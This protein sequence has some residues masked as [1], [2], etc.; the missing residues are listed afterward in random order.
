MTTSW[1]THPAG[2]GSS[3]GTHWITSCRGNSNSSECWTEE[4]GR[5]VGLHRYEDCEE[6]S[7][8]HREDLVNYQVSR[9]ES[10]PIRPIASKKDEKEGQTEDT[11]TSNLLIK[12]PNQTMAR[13]LNVVFDKNNIDHAEIRYNKD[14]QNDSSSLWVKCETQGKNAATT[15]S[16]K[17]RFNRVTV[18]ADKHLESVS[19]EFPVGL[20]R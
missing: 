19:C 14:V 20:R 12:L 11:L 9:F 6:R 3:S 5:M 7:R 18:S 13:N 17:R 16:F 15:F 2:L 10:I 8:C 1:T 4:C